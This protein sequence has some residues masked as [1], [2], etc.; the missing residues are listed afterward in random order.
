[1][2]HGY[3][4]ALR[5]A[6]LTASTLV[7]IGWIFA[8]E[9]VAQDP[10]DSLRAAN[11]AYLK[12]IGTNCTSDV[13]SQAAKLC[14]QGC[15]ITIPNTKLAVAD[16]CDPRTWA[17]AWPEQAV[18][19]DK[20]CPAGWTGSY[21]QDHWY[22]V[23]NC[24]S[25][26]VD[27]GK[28][29][30]LTVNCT[31]DRVENRTDPCPGAQGWAGGGVN[32]SRTHHES[33]GLDLSTVTETGVTA[34]A[35]TSMD[36]HRTVNRT[37]NATCDATPVAIG[38]GGYAT[39]CQTDK[40][41]DGTVLANNCPNPLFDPR[42]T[43]ASTIAQHLASDLVSVVTDS[44]TS[45]GTTYADCPPPPPPPPCTTCDPGDTGGDLGG[46]GGDGMGGDGDGDAGGAGD[47][48]DGSGS[49][50]IIWH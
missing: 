35:I 47:G 17:C 27:T 25:N 15:M 10:H 42:T 21:H 24:G 37:D 46:G 13:Q 8:Q 39:S 1:M 23:Q 34:W 4:I 11:E 19:E 32:Y 43:T 20:A 7:P 29:K 31:R 45:G 36:C 38:S 48:D 22:Q 50:S 3:N 16:S 14:P 6:G 2:R 28:T 49:R 41:A 30:V 33:L 26:M 18:G 5:A 12:Q 44:I 9:R 40:L